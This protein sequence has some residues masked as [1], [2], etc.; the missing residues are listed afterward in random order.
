MAWP[1]VLGGDGKPPASPDPEVKNDKPPEKDLATIIAESLAPMNARFEAL[2]GKLNTLSAPPAPPKPASAE[3]PSVLDDENAAF[4]ARL[5]PVLQHTMEVEAKMV[6]ND[7]E[8]EYR[9]KGFGDLWD[10]H[11]K[12][13]EEFLDVTPLVRQDPGGKIVPHRGDA[14][15]VRN[16]AD[17]FIG[18]AV[19]DKGIRFDGKDKRFFL[20]DATGDTDLLSRRPAENEG[21]TKKQIEAA[22]K[23]GI[24]VADYKKAAGKLDFVQ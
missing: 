1:K 21:L 22:K 18:K 6:R 12:G 14:N 17:M 13:I 15:V 23:F 20:E 11:R 7:I 2:E 24:P 19:R 16:V 5:T 10:E 9:A 4:A 3:I 8:R